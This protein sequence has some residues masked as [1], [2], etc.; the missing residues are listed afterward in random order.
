M[1]IGNNLAIIYLDSKIGC[2]KTSVGISTAL[3]VNYVMLNI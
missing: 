2:F 3:N 1:K